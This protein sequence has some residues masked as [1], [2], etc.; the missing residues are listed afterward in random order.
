MHQRKNRMYNTKTIEKVKDTIVSIDSIVHANRYPGFIYLIVNTPAETTT[1]FIGPSWFVNEQKLKMKSGDSVQVTGA[2]V[3]LEGR[4][5]IIARQ[6]M[7]GNVGIM[8]RDA[9]GVP[10]WR[11]GR[12]GR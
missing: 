3:S 5:V 4:P 2:R 6:V 1:V 7:V 10:L 9:Q 12:G 8:L 11:G